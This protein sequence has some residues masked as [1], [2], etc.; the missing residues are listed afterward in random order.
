MQ[1]QFRVPDE[2]WRGYAWSS[3]VNFTPIFNKGQT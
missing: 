3:Q 2:K 1:R